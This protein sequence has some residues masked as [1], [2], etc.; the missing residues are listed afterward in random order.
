MHPP[1][2]VI[3]DVIAERIVGL[4]TS[5]PRILAVLGE[6]RIYIYAGDA[7]EDLRTISR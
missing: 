7:E 4:D 5:D 1:R 3:P 6:Q 2:R